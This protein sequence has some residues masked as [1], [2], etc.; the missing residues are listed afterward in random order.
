MKDKKHPFDEYIVQGETSRRQRAENWQ[1]AIGLQDVDRLQNSPYL[2][3]TAKE[4]IEGN[5]DFAAGSRH[6]APN[7]RTIR[8]GILNP[9]RDIIEVEYLTGDPC[10]DRT[11]GHGTTRHLQLAN[12]L[13][14]ALAGLR[15]H[16]L[17]IDSKVHKT[18]S[19]SIHSKFMIK[20]S[21][22]TSRL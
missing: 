5:I 1:I 3:E 7:R 11:V 6:R 8:H 22:P 10:H 20:K 14:Q 21:A 17:S 16:F 9:N 13:Q 12:Q 19:V 2:L 15:C 18:T 4:H